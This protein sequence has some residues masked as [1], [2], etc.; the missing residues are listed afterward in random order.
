MLFF[1]RKA[2]SFLRWTERNTAVFST[3]SYGSFFLRSGRSVTLEQTA[4]YPAKRVLQLRF[5]GDFLVQ[6]E[7]VLL[8]IL[9]YSRTGK[10]GWRLNDEHTVYLCAHPVLSAKEIVVM[11]QKRLPFG[12]LRY[13]GGRRGIWTLVT[14]VMGKTVFETAAFSRSAILPFLWSCS[15]EQ[16]QIC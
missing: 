16:N 12:S 6:I 15:C 4:F 9:K 8:S 3:C 14:H 11:G 1:I 13:S 10:A 7:C 2:A 5:R